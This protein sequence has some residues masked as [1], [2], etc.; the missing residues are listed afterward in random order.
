MHLTIDDV[1][2]GINEPC[3]ISEVKT[4]PLEIYVRFVKLKELEKFAVVYNRKFKP[5]F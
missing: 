4:L 5:Y 1:F 2:E 3:S